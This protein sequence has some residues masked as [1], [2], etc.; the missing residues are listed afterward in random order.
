MRGLGL[1]RYL[2]SVTALSAVSGGMSSTPK[3]KSPGRKLPTE[4][5]V[6]VDEALMQKASTIMVLFFASVIVLI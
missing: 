4:T 6:V 1:S 5:S 3:T 2:V